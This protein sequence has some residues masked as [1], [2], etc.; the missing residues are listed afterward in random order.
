MRR[1]NAGLAALLAIGFFLAACS[2]KDDESKPVPA[3]E[4]L[5]NRA[6][7]ALE[8]R[9][10]KD[11]I[12]D[13]EEIERTYPFSP[14][15]R[16]AQL[17]IAY[18]H[19]DNQKYDDAIVALDYYIK[20]HPGHKDVVYAYYLK[21]ISYYDQITDV[22]R[23]QSI[24]EQ[25]RSSLQE[26]VARFPESEYARDA[27]IKLDLVVDH[28]A[29]KE[30]NIGRFY[31]KQRYY[32]AASRRFQSV[33][34]MFQTTTH[35]PEALHRLVESYVSLGVKEEAQKYAAVLGHNYPG[36]KWYEYSYNL[37]TKRG[38]QKSPSSKWLNL[39]LPWFKKDEVSAELPAPTA[40]VEGTGEGEKTSNPPL[41]HEN[42]S[43][44]ILN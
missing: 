4:V 13:F 2:G 19:Y 37:L 35:T 5:Y 3:V 28:L 18:S 12:A 44:E 22:G 26:V 20:L 33:V 17:M 38:I 24:T 32:V 41:T 39:R 25:A 40:G 6:M 31:L 23:E 14:W 34:E 10:F 15:T 27:K 29:G 8:R 42:L 21:A 11:A 16:R 9:K 7:D 30:M 36:S 1:I 43:R